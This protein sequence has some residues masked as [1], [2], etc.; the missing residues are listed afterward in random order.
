MSWRDTVSAGQQSFLV[1]PN[2]KEEVLGHGSFSPLRISVLNG[3]EDPEVMVKDGLLVLMCHKDLLSVHLNGIADQLVN[4]LNQV[5]KDRVVSRCCNFSVE[6]EVKLR[7][8][9]PFLKVSLHLF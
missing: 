5:E 6:L 3:L 4:V 8:N 7:P 1:F 2:D 9:L